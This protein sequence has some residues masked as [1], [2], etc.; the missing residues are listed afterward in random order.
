[1][2]D[3]FYFRDMKRNCREISFYEPDDVTFVFKFSFA[4]PLHA[5]IISIIYSIK[6]FTNANRWRISGEDFETLLSECDTIDH[7]TKRDRKWD[8]SIGMCADAEST[9]NIISMANNN[10]QKIPTGKG[11]GRAR[12]SNGPHMD[13]LRKY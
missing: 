4:E 8:V 3:V 2:K 10:N 13:Q 6:N 9:V 5:N 11:E 12:R 7:G 1:M